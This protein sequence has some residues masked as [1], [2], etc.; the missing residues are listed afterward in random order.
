MGDWG[1]GD[2]WT[3]A[4]GM[5]RGSVSVSCARATC[6]AHANPF[7]GAY[8]SQTC[9]TLA[10]SARMT[11]AR[12]RARPR[13][14]QD[15]AVEIHWGAERRRHEQEWGVSLGEDQA[16]ARAVVRDDRERRADWV[17]GHVREAVPFDGDQ[18]IAELRARAGYVPPELRRAAPP[19]RTA[20]PSQ[21]GGVIYR[22]IP[23]GGVVCSH[24]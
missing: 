7:G 10:T 8:C 2:Y 17:A 4:D 11:A 14:L 5:P 19:A 12:D 9:Q 23:G 18:Y 13:E 22:R 21:R 6:G 16:L 3:R 20:P 1:N 15:R 24:G